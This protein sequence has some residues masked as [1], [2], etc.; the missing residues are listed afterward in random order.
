MCLFLGQIK[1][2]SSPSSC[3]TFPVFSVEYSVEL[4]GGFSMGAA[5]S[6]YYGYQYGRTLAGIFA[7]SGFLNNDSAVYEV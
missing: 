5:L 4:A 7:L 1:K 6:L 3:R 2:S